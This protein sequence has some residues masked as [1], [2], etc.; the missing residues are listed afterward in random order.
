MLD[1][2]SIILKI[3]I[4]KLIIALNITFILFFTCPS[5]VWAMDEIFNTSEY[6][7]GAGST[8]TSYNVNL[9]DFDRNFGTIVLEDQDL[10]NMLKERLEVIENR[11]SQGST[12]GSQNPSS[13]KSEASNELKNL[14][15]SYFKNRNQ[16]GYNSLKNMASSWTFQNSLDDYINSII[17]THLQNKEQNNPA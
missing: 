4:K 6:D 11:P 16:Q 14:V 13:F 5:L 8:N 1:L 3:V 15:E 10:K 17:K 9:E 7:P 2:D 12:S